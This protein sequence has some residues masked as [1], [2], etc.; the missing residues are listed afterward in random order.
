MYI[1]MLLYLYTSILK[2]GYSYILIVLITYIQLYAIILC[3]K[4]KVIKK[5]TF[6]YK[7]NLIFYNKVL[8]INVITSFTYISIYK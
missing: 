3:F 4:V 2:W 8:V 1:G 7:S 5:T 6:Y